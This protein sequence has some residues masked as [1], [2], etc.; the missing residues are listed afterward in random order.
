MVVAFWNIGVAVAFWNTWVAVTF[1]NIGVAV[2]FWNNWVAVAFW[3]IGVAVAF[4]N[5]GVGVAFWNIGVAVASCNMP[6]LTGN[7]NL[8][9]H[10]AKCLYY[11]I[12]DA[13]TIWQPWCSRVRMLMTSCRAEDSNKQPV[14]HVTMAHMIQSKQSR[15]WPSGLFYIRLYSAHN[16][17]DSKIEISAGPGQYT[18]IHW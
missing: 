12:P 5:I 16:N 9:K 7:H 3:N 17:V 15:P 1:W 11:F 18:V 13:Y 14:F 10:P 6:K 4:W 2:A 8:V